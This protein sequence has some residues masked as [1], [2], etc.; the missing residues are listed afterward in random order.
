MRAYNSL[1][2]FSRLEKANEVNLKPERGDLRPAGADWR[3]ER[4]DLRFERID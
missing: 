3:F 1:R 4:A 2:A